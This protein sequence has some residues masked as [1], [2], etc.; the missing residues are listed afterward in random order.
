MDLSRRQL[1]GGMAGYAFAPLT[2]L[3][4]GFMKGTAL[5][6][7]LLPD[8]RRDFRDAFAIYNTILS[9]SVRG[10]VHEQGVVAEAIVALSQ[11][12]KD[13]A[14]VIPAGPLRHADAAGI[15]RL[16]AD[17]HR[18]IVVFSDH[19]LTLGAHR[20]NVFSGESGSHFQHA[21]RSLYLAVLDQYH[22]E[23]WTLVENGDAEDLVVFDTALHPGEFA[24]RRRAVAESGLPGL[25][26]RRSEF[27]A[28]LLADILADPANREY[29]AALTRFSDAGR[30]VRIGGNHDYQVPKFWE[31]AVARAS[32]VSGVRYPPLEVHASIAV[33]TERDAWRTLIL[34]GHQFDHVSSPINAPRHGETIS[35]CLGTFYQG[36]DRVWPWSESRQWVSGR[37]FRNLLVSGLPTSA[38][39]LQQ[40]AAGGGF[41]TASTADARRRLWMRTGLGP[42]FWEDTFGHP[43]AWDYFLAPGATD[44]LD[45]DS[46]EQ[47]YRAIALGD[48]WFKFRH[49]EELDLAALLPEEMGGTP[50]NVVLGHTHEPRCG[51]IDANGRPVEWYLN[52]GAAGRFEG[53]LWGVEILD[54]EAAVVSWH[55]DPWPDGPP[56]RRIW[57]AE[58]EWRHL[59]VSRPRALG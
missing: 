43:I 7:G 26:A 16:D 6:Y 23:G 48:A 38:Q 14:G 29:Y 50:P 34:H 22:R 49:T 51:A 44:D 8:E 45:G 31:E 33:L 47:V 10:R 57:R 5:Q 46:V 54:G 4:R 53:L 59:L 20:H 13:R 41:S 42:N 35:E 24:T 37:P 12:V 36:G 11:V 25:V 18:R 52:S 40:M 17:V 1:F 32:R 9:P 55:P 30:L 56:T 2:G 3:Q 15:E 58:G 28:G 27:R 39:N 19:H 21:N